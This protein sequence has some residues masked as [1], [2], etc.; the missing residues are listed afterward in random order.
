MVWNIKPILPKKS[1]SFLTDPRDIQLA[2][3]RAMPESMD[4]YFY[5]NGSTTIRQ[6]REGEKEKAEGGC[7]KI[8]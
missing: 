2:I 1:S 5:V 6:T 8:D 7:L 4:S 3:D